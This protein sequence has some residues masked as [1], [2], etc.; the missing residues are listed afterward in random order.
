[1]DRWDCVVAGQARAGYG[2]VVQPVRQRSG[3]RARLKISFP[4]LGP[5]LESAVLATWAGRGAVL[6]YE[7]DDANRARLLEELKTTSLAEVFDGDESMFVVGRLARR[8]AVPAPA[9]NGVGLPRLSEACTRWESELTAA[10]TIVGRLP[11]RTIEA[12]IATCREL[13]P[14]Q[15]D[16][17]LHG[18][19]HE[20]N[21]LRGRREDWL[22]IDPLGVVGD[23]STECLTHLRDRWVDLQRQVDPVR[24]LHRRIEI[25]AEAADVE[26]ARVRRWTQTRAAVTSIRSQ[27]D[28]AS[29]DDYGPHDWLAETLTS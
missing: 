15:P 16:T 24:A 10:R 11:T 19:L 8:L 18:D 29:A 12:A 5:D 1:M 27:K 21:V 22:A 13:G 7:R 28:K 9:T 17:L 6:M 14:T 20:R 23:I 26:P 2:G 3:R 4:D 25:F